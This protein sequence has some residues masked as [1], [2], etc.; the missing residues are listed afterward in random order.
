MQISQKGRGKDRR[1]VGSWLPHTL[2]LGMRPSFPAGVQSVSWS[3]PQPCPG[4]ASKVCPMLPHCP[5]LFSQH[6]FSSHLLPS[7]GEQTSHHSAVP[8]WSNSSSKAHSGLEQQRENKEWKE[9]ERPPECCREERREET[10]GGGPSLAIHQQERKT[11]KEPSPAF[12]CPWQ[13]VKHRAFTP[14]FHGL[15]FWR[16]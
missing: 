9:N 13:G 2:R 14:V 16:W 6:L 10:T 8:P 7:P 5:G 12:L 11:F 3:P 4:V 15:Y 1:S